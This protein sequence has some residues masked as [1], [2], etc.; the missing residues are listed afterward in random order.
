M[1]THIYP[2]EF[3]KLPQEH[4]ELLGH[5]YG[6]HPLTVAE[7]II[8][9]LN[10]PDCSPMARKMVMDYKNEFPKLMKILKISDED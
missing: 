4:F 10:S 5:F 9:W 3:E 8:T 1:K 6:L 2:S 7:S